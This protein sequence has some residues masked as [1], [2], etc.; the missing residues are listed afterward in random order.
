MAS[1]APKSAWLLTYH[2]VDDMDNKRTPFRANHL[3]RLKAHADK[4]EILLAG[5]WSPTT[6]GTIVWNNVDKAII[7]KF[8]QGDPYY[9]NGLITKFEICRWLLPVDQVGLSAKLNS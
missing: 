5:A 6:G 8:V 4:N 9:V 1:A 2:Y 7:E 3:A